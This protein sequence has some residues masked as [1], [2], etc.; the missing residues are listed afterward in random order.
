MNA[1]FVL[2]PSHIESMRAVADGADVLA[3]GMAKDLRDVQEHY[4]TY[5]RITVRMGTY[6]ATERLPYFGAILTERGKVAVATEKRCSRC[7]EM[8]PKDAE[9]FRPRTAGGGRFMPWCRACESDQKAQARQAKT[10][11]GAAIAK[12]TGGAS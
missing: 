11:A 4:P 5:V 1:R 7:R 2:T 12:A 6:K 9:F 8:W 10:T 3:Y